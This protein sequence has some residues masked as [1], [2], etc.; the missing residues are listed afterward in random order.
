MPVMREELQKIQKDI[1]VIGELSKLNPGGSRSMKD[2]THEIQEMIVNE[3]MKNNKYNVTL[4]SRVLKINRGSARKI[5]ERHHVRDALKQ[6]LDNFKDE[7]RQSQLSVQL[8]D[9]V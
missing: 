8:V 4:T 6:R 1:D 7:F 2:I 5:I 9:C 3:V